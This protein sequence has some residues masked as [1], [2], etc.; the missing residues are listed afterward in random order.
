MSDLVLGVTSALGGLVVFVAAIPF[1]YL[2]DRT[3][4]TTL[5]AAASGMWAILAI[6]CGAV[7]ATWQ[8]AICWA[9]R[10]V[11]AANEQPVHSALL[12]DGYPIE[13]RNRIYG[14]HRAAQPLGLVFGPVLAGFIASIAGGP[15]G[16]RWAFVVLALPAVA[17]A[18]AIAGVR[19]PPRGRNEMIEVLGE[20]LADIPDELPIPISA[21]FARLKKVKTF[22]YFLCALGA[23]GL[24]FVAAPVYSNLVLQNHFHLDAAGRGVVG[25]ISAVGGLIG[26]AVGG[27]LGD[28]LFRQ[29][30]E[31]SML[32]TGALVALFG[33]MFP[34]AV[35]M[36]NPVLYTVC[37]VIGLAM[38]FAAFVP[39][40]AIVAAVTPYRLRSMGF[41]TVGLYLSLVGGL[42]GALLV[43]AIADAWGD[44]AALA[45]VCPPAALLGGALIALGARHV[46]ADMAMAANDLLEEREERA[47]INAGGEV[48]MLQV[49]HLDFSYGS[50]QVLFD[51]NLDIR[52]GEVLA[53]LG[54]NGAGK[55]TL[56]RAI[57]GLDYADRGAVRLA[58]R[59]VTFAEPGT[60]VRL[61]IVQVPGGRAVF[62]TLTVGE[63][64]MAGAYSFI[65]DRDRVEE[66]AERVLGL[67]PV[68]ADRLDQPA[69]TL[70]GGEQQMLGL[71]SALLLEPRILL[72]DELSLGLAP[73]VVEQLLHTVESL[74]G[75]GL[76][77]VIVEQSVNIALSIADRAVFMEKG[78]VRFEGPAQDLLERDDLVRAVFL[79]GEGG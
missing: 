19:E 29:A 65:W 59:T 9:L 67:F 3:R 41:A 56:L 15:S 51:V 66:R 78:Q 23:L 44:R 68:L 33:V 21:A 2:A 17:L 48:P 5:V 72:I 27:T 20:E 34:L 11:G 10:G 37:N 38:V 45:V 55:S 79:G 73:V 63:N 18:V 40:S 46:R 74:K 61:G 60:R 13:G 64:L 77:M 69:G 54:T 62:P 14:L 22:N 53:L 75:T 32:L 70:S 42:G 71:A 31:R 28:R 24:A 52:E 30:P 36:P 26:V 39:T 35:F 57:S 47:R 58:G 4:R 8:L 7:R 43:G 16:W 49:R 76:T 12:A 25:S 1:G 50:V 6:A